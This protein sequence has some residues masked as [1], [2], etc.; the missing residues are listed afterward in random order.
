MRVL[1]VPTAIFTLCHR[2][3]LGEAARRVLGKLCQGLLIWER[4]RRMA[5]FFESKMFVAAA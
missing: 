4:W 3:G 5:E 1:I 2:L